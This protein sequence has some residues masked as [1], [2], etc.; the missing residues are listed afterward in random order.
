M[1]AAASS[2]EN[3]SSSGNSARIGGSEAGSSTRKRPLR[4]VSSAHM[5]D[6]LIERGGPSKPRKNTLPARLAREYE[7]DPVQPA[8]AISRGLASNSARC[9]RKVS[10]VNQN[11]TV[12]ETLTI[13]SSVPGALPSGQ[14]SVAP[15]TLPHFCGCQ[16]ISES[17]ESAFQSSTASRI[18][19]TRDI[20]DSSWRASFGLRAWLRSGVAVASSG[21]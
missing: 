6:G 8:N 5:A 3:C 18:G 20:S 21:A 4:V 9:G 15:C 16:V 10:A 7:L 14:I 11:C 19:A 17:S 12:S 13:S 2:A 1:K